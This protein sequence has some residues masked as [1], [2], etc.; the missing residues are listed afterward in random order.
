MNNIKCYKEI[1][2]GVGRDCPRTIN[3]NSLHLSSYNKNKRML[4]TWKKHSILRSKSVPV[5]PTVTEELTNEPNEIDYISD[6]TSEKSIS[7]SSEDY[8]FD[9]SVFGVILKNNDE[10]SDD[11]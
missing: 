8:K 3:Y 7:D 10:S 9:P 5:L 11:E 6:V 4:N 2:Y 1:H